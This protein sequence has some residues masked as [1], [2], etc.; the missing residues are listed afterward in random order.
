MGAAAFV[1]GGGTFGSFRDLARWTPPPKEEEAPDPL[2][3]TKKLLIGVML[4]GVAVYFGVGGTFANFQAETSN[5]GSSISSGTL[6]LGDAVN[7]TACF[8]YSAATADNV[9]AGCNA[10]FTATVVAPGT[11]QSTQLAKIDVSNAGSIDG[12]NLYLYASQINGKLSAT[13]GLTNLSAV[14]S[15]S[16]A[17]PGMEGTVSNND[18][19]TV[20]YGG[21]AQTFTVSGTPTPASN[22]NG[23]ATTINVVTGQN[24]N[25]DYPAGSTVQDTS[26]NTAV[27]NTD[28][29]DTKLAGD[30]SWN[31]NSITASSRTQQTFN[32]FCG[33]LVMWI[34]E[35]SAGKTYC[36]WGKGSTYSSGS[37]TFG[38]ENA[39]GLC[40]APIYAT[41][42]GISGTGVT[43]IPIS[44]SGG[45][46]GNV[47]DGDSIVVTQGP[48][49]QTFMANGAS[50]VGSNSIAIHSATVGTAFT[51]GAVVTD[52]SATGSLD[53]N[54][55]T[56]T[57]SNFDTGHHWAGGKLELYPIASSGSFNN[58]TGHVDLPAGT[59][60]TFYVGVYLPKPSGS[61]QNP[62]QGL[63]ST[64]GL[65]WHLDQSSS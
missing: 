41:T 54:S 63:T 62:L 60:R 37:T 6:V 33:S 27:T 9:N 56:D 22:S 40:V 45:L 21:H 59:M 64:F 57:I 61:V 13:G 12:Q 18:S 53:G 8:S 55:T 2:W 3:K 25:A 35:L 7:G 42:S 65:T 48:T 1:G 11:L 23:G 16:I 32:P 31:F 43:S 46:N 24:A 47:S 17:S 4:I 5:N 38:T 34:Q 51:S 49:T 15:L 10:P 20:S 39:G 14:S 58:G 28:C 36:W 19:V 26:G 30:A 44:T 29:Y 52:T 50:P